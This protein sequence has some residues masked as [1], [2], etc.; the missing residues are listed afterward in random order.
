MK[1]W[2]ITVDASCVLCQ[3]PLESTTHLFFECAYSAQV[4]EALMKGILQD[5]YSVNWENLIRLVTERQ[6]WDKTKIFTVRYAIQL[7]IYSIWRERNRRRHG[8]LAVPASV[9]SQRLDK[10][11]RNQF[12]VICR[13]DV[14]YEDGM[15]KW[16]ETR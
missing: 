7:V 14:S 6:S 16:F 13:R 4:W 5:Q 9:L 3:E 12:F 15:T 10:T 2:N 8:K 1:S 11:M